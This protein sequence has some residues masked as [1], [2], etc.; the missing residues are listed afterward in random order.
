MDF[1]DPGFSRQEAST[2]NSCAENRH[3][4]YMENVKH[5]LR[6]SACL[7]MKR[8][9][10]LHEHELLLCTSCRHFKKKCYVKLL[11]LNQQNS[12]AAVKEFLRMKQIR[13]G[14]MC[15]TQDDTDIWGNL[16]FF[17]A[18]DEST[19]RLLATKM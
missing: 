6:Y 19:P 18:E 11:Y 9:R 7:W 8:M 15:S 14:S 10:I 1:E 4:A 3:C 17:Q 5:H 2:S 13:R 16:A 12:V